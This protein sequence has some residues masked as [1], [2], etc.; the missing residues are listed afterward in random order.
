MCSRQDVQDIV[1]KAFKDYTKQ[2]NDNLNNRLALQKE[3]FFDFVE[4]QVKSIP[5]HKT[6]PETRNEL[7]KLHNN[8][9]ERGGEIRS[10]KEDM[11]EIKQSLTNINSKID[12]YNDVAVEFKIVRMVVFGLVAMILM[13]VFGSILAL[14]IMSR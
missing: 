5:L 9:I 7:T 13:S 14:V 8:C 3:E 12:R 11:D 6:S 4:R 1:D 10:M 2:R